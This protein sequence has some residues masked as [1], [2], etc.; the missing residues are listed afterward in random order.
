M[1]G[2][3]LDC[4]D[5]LLNNFTTHITLYCVYIILV[6]IHTH[7]NSGFLQSNCLWAWAFSGLFGLDVVQIRMSQSLII[8]L[9]TSIYPTLI[10]CIMYA[11][12]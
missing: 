7:G 12:G 6:Y 3:V 2:W 4:E 9:A 8:P 11:E 5:P 10:L 1:F